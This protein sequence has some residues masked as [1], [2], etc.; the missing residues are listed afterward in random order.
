[1]GE[2][3]VYATLLKLNGVTRFSWTMDLDS[4]APEAAHSMF[5]LPDAFSRDD[6]RAQGRQ[7]GDTEP[8]LG[9]QRG[10]L[11]GKKRGRKKICGNDKAL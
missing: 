10:K 7:E 1:M 3:E 5:M 11:G 9:S 8:E 2:T 6:T 4:P